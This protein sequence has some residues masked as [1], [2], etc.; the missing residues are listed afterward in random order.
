MATPCK[1]EWDDAYHPTHREIWERVLTKTLDSSEIMHEFAEQ[2]ATRRDLINKY[3]FEQ[4]FYPVHGIFVLHPTK[5]LRHVGQV[6]V[7]GAQDPELVEHLGFTQ[8]RTVEE[9]I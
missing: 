6:F 3:R 8:T 1:N 9:A 2:F 4:A 5:R 7:A